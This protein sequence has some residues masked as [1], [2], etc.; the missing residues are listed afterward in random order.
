M[1]IFQD[2]VAVKEAYEDVW[3]GLD[4][5]EQEQ[6]INESIIRP[7][8]ILRY[9]GHVAIRDSARHP[10]ANTAEVRLSSFGVDKVFPRFKVQSG[11]K[12]NTFE[13]TSGSQGEDLGSDCVSSTYFFLWKIQLTCLLV[14]GVQGMFH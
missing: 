3:T 14:D 6:I 8:A 12:E 5:S 11:Q 1:L 2:V 10:S 4:V 13:D 9:E 7:D